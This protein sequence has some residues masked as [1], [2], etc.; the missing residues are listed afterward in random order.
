MPSVYVS[1]QDFS[2]QKITSRFICFDKNKKL[3]TKWNFFNN[4]IFLT[5]LTYIF[6]SE[7]KTFMK[8]FK[9]HLK[10]VYT[11]RAVTL[12]CIKHK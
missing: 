10:R 12:N 9:K 2:V 3:T 8:A 11:G 1:L 7:P 6:F 4:F 5:G